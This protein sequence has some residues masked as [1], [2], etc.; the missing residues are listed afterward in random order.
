MKSFNF[1]F[2]ASLGQLVLRHSDNLSRT[3]QATSMSAAEGQ[4]IARM[5]LSTMQ[6]IRSDEMFALFWSSVKKRASDLN[7][8]EPDLP[9]QRRIP[10]R[11]DEGSANAD[12]PSTT[13]NHYKR[14][15][16]EALDLVMNGIK[17]RFDQP[18]YKVY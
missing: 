6:S 8:N 17:N 16:F 7:I 14:I 13:E 10:R 15:Y 12:F 2:G 3:L 4:K 11:Y 5:T 1:F 9:R 18:G